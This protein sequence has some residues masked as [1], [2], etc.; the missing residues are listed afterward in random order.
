MS[1]LVTFN[2]QLISYV[3]WEVVNYETKISFRPYV[4]LFDL[5]INT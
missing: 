5:Y 3:T 1:T 4:V 2:L